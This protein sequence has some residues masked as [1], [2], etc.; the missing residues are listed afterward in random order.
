MQNVQQEQANLIAIFFSTLY[1]FFFYFWIAVVTH[2]LTVV[3]HD[4]KSVTP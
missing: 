1:K 4:E 3:L 2:E